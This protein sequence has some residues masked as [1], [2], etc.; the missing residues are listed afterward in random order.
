MIGVRID[1]MT[2]GTGAMIAET[3][4]RTP[5][6]PV[7]WFDSLRALAADAGFPGQARVNE[8]EADF[9]PR[10]HPE[11]TVNCVRFEGW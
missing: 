11:T 7:R 4:V 2:V 3:D 5:T 10:S 8:D 6:D 9:G 1:A